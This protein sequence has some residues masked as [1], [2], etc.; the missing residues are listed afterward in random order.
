MSTLLLESKQNEELWSYSKKKEEFVVLLN[1]INYNI[2][3]EID[4]HYEE[5]V[6]MGGCDYTS[7]VQITAV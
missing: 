1:F 5:I 6:S 7:H 2:N 4:L 3:W